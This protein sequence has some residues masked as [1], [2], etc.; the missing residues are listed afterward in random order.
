MSDR[1]TRD[2]IEQARLRYRASLAGSSGA[3][4]RLIA[5]GRDEAADALADA[6]ARIAELEAA[7][8]DTDAEVA[9][10]VEAERARNAPAEAESPMFA[11]RAQ[12]KRDRLDGSADRHAAEVQ[13]RQDHENSLRATE[14][15]WR[16]LTAAD[17]KGDQ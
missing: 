15:R 14:E 13:R 2:E 9:R 16:P 5:Q 6:R 12:T 17:L 4:D 10:A 3:A 7:Q 11:A 1:T 8:T